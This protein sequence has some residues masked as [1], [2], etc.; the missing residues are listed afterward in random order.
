MS[1]EKKLN[2]Y[3]DGVGE[4]IGVEFGKYLALET[5]VSFP[6]LSLTIL[7]EIYLVDKK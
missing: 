7:N 5:M 2:D 1:P 6:L 3:A 4:Y